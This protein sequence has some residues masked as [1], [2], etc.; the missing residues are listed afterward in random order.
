[1]KKFNN[2]LV[3]G[4]TSAIC[5]AVLKIL[6]EQT[7]HFFLAARD[8]SRLAA[9]TQDLKTRGATISG[10][11][12]FDFNHVDSIQSCVDSA[13]NKMGSL[14]LILVAHGTLPDNELLEKDINKAIESINANFTSCAAIVL[15]SCQRLE[16]QGS[17]TLAV[18]SSVAGDRGRKTN[19]IYGA[20]KSALNTLLQG[21]QGRFSGTNIRIVNIKPGMIDTPMTRDFQKGLLWSTPE[22]IAPAIYK[23]ILIGK[24]NCYVPSYWRLIMLIIKFLPAAILY[25]LPI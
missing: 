22:K 14:D 17:G 21:L 13:S 4:A 7:C 18:I 20:S 19:Y 6:S 8:E 24:S 10:T 15:E 11:S 25:R 23:A 5:H 9:I 2:I 1:M 12:S 16:A 3:F